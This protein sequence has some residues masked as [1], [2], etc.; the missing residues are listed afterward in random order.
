MVN[1]CRHFQRRIQKKWRGISHGFLIFKEGSKK[2]TIQK[3]ISSGGTGPLLG[4]PLGHFISIGY[5]NSFERNKKSGA[6]Q[7]LLIT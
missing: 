3:I 4:T 5:D 2:S 1:C 6:K 7:N